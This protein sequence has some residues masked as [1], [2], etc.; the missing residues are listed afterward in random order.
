MKD[1]STLPLFPEIGISD[2]PPSIRPGGAEPRSRR[3]GQRPAARRSEI[4]ERRRRGGIVV[5]ELPTKELLN[6]CD[7]PKMPFAWTVNPY[8]GCEFACS[9]CYAR[10]THEYLGYPRNEVFE[11]FEREIWAKI[12]GESSLTVDKIERAAEVGAIAIGT[13][14]DPYQSAEEKFQITRRILARFAE[15]PGLRLSITTKSPLVARDVDLLWRIAQRSR[16][17]VHISIPTSDDALAR[18]LEPRAPSPTRRLETIRSLAGAGIDVRL[19]LI[20]VV[21]LVT[22]S[23]ERVR[24]TLLAAKEHGV[25]GAICNTM[26]VPAGWR[27]EGWVWL[28]DTFPELREPFGNFQANPALF[29]AER[30]RIQARVRRLIHELDM[31]PPAEEDRPAVDVQ[32]GLWNEVSYVRP[33]VRRRSVHRVGAWR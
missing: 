12:G 13:A 15:V 29:E 16:L 1:Q 32:R 23:D 20:P 7:N 24:E 9:Y 2:S 10:P 3:A 19:N 26:F 25:R 4:V 31:D 28:I 22:D 14:T 8:R 17:S 33:P 5:R 11:A 30:E 27:A 21:P 6:R 18:R